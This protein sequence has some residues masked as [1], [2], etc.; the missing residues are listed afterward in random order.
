MLSPVEA[1]AAVAPSGLTDVVIIDAQ[2]VFT[3]RDYN[4][5]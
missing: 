4:D 2:A 3:A 5:R 1:A